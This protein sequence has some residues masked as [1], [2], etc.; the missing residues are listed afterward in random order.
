[1][2]HP[3]AGA[4]E[5]FIANLRFCMDKDTLWHLID[6]LEKIPDEDEEKLYAAL[7]ILK[8][9]I[10]TQYKVT[11]GGRLALVVIGDVLQVVE[12]IYTPDSLVSATINLTV[13][14]G[15][16]GKIVVEKG[17]EYCQRKQMDET[18]ETDSD[19]ED[20]IEL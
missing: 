9:N 5:K 18:L 7:K 16:A 17:L 13:S 2:N 1:M 15:Y 10:E 12:K 19:Q 6:K 11:L 14:V 4:N 20:N 3:T 8:Q